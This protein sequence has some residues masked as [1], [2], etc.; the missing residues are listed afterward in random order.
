MATGPKDRTTDDMVNWAK[1]VDRP[2]R[3]RCRKSPMSPLDM[4]TGRGEEMGRDYR[5]FMEEASKVIPEIED[6]DQT[7][8]DWIIAALDA[9]KIS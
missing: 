1:H 6:K 4:H 5:Y 2:R 8:R 7:Y 9:G 3:K